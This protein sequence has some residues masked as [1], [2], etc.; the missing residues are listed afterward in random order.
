VKTI[1]TIILALGVAGV[2]AAEEKK[3]EPKK[4]K[5]K[6]EKKSDKNAAQKADSAFI[7]FMHD[8][9]IWID[10]SSKK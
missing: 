6:A 1:L 2:H 5:P 7:H 3:S 10:R 4:S 9:K 8:N